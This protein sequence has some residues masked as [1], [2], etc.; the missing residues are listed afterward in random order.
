[1]GKK[2]N[3]PNRALILIVFI[4]LLAVLFFIAAAF[5][6]GS[7]GFKMDKTQN[8]LLVSKVV[9]PFNPIQKGDLIVALSGV[10]YNRTLGYLFFP[11]G[12]T[13]EPTITLE[14]NTTLFS[15]KIRTVPLTLTLLT[16]TVWP[17]VL[18]ISFF[19]IFALLA[20][21]RAPHS[22]QVDLFF[23]MLCS[24][25]TS[26]AATLASSLG[27]LQ[28][29]VVSASFLLLTASNWLSF[30]AWLHFACRF[31][32]SCDLFKRKKWP[33]F[34]I[35]LL[36]SL[37]PV[38]LSLLAGGVSFSFWGWLQRFRNIFLPIIIVLA[39]CKHLWDYRHLAV[40]QVK[41]QLKLPLVAYWMTFAPY[42]FLL[43][44]TRLKA[45]SLSM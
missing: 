9:S 27:L 25:S 13:D 12:K 37:V 22:V 10:S 15:L 2:I 30:G 14:R 34:T 19:L 45:Y 42:L 21:F 32:A 24:L 23:L 44:T 36:L 28:P 8:G 26:I 16:Q 29:E 7:S 35:Y 4:P 31:P 5:N 43:Q 40:S 38:G 41:N 6:Q 18:L 17:R 20:R 39:F 1:M 11:S 33:I 3:K